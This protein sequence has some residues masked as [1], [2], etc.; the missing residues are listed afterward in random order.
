[1]VRGALDLPGAGWLNRRMQK[2]RWLVLAGIVAG[3][4]AWGT[5]GR[6]ADGQEAAG[7]D[8]DACMRYA[9]AHSLAVDN[10]RLDREL[11]ATRRDRVEG[12]YDPRFE[13]RV[14]YLDSEI[15][16]GTSVFL[17]DRR[18]TSADLSLA[19]AFPSG[20]LVSL[21]AAMN[22][23]DAGGETGAL[24]A[25][26]YS[27]S[28]ALTVTQSLLSNAF[29]DVDRARRAAAEWGVRAAEDLDRRQ[30]R[31][32]AAHIAERYWQLFSARRRYGTARQ[33]EERA[34]R[35]LDANRQRE[36][37]GLIEQTDV[38]STDALLGARRTDVLA[39]EKAARDAEDA[40]KFAMQLPPTAWAATA[41]RL[42]DE[43]REAELAAALDLEPAAVCERALKARA[44]LAALQRREEQARLEVQI[45][46]DDRQHDLS[47]FGQVGRGGG[48][49][50]FEGS[51]NLDRDAWSVGLQFSAAWGRVAASSL[52]E[53]ARL[54][55]ERA[56]NDR[57]LLEESVWL[58]CAAAVRAVESGAARLAEARRVR[59]VQEQRLEL[60]TAK[61][62]QGRSSLNWLIQ[63]EDDLATARYAYHAA[64]ADYRTAIAR[65]RLAAG[66]DVT[67][68][69]R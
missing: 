26:P 8:L 57:R 46:A 55:L 44:D 1:M 36:A 59:E 29:G 4:C 43:E 6:A 24:V 49:D 32:L 19:K 65:Y 58:E 37:E 18:V 30:Q 31:L 38:L 34:R 53:E 12:A 50:G 11:A 56:V 28:L 42:P 3:L 69:G 52:L 14:A 21:G 67:E 51:W 68:A 47:V 25:E 63:Y 10:A 20:T 16:D 41:I 5:H 23:L 13:A 15:R 33:A 2:G 62:E 60:E 45:R 17:S 48:D 54:A 64:L 27:A 61:F 35:L 39:L 7:W 40:L 9:L 22:R 66:A